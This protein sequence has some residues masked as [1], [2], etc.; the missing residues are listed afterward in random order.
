MSRIAIPD[1]M[2]VHPKS[3]PYYDYTLVEQAFDGRFMSYCSSAG[4]VLYFILYAGDIAVIVWVW[5]HYWEELWMIALSDVSFLCL[6]LHIIGHYL[7]TRPVRGAIRMVQVRDASNMPLWRLP[8]LSEF[9]LLTQSWSIVRWMIFSYVTCI[10]GPALAALV[11]LLFYLVDAVLTKNLVFVVVFCAWQL[12]SS[13][14][15]RAA[16]NV[17]YQNA[18]VGSFRSVFADSRAVKKYAAARCATAV[19]Q[20]LSEIRPARKNHRNG[21]DVAWESS[22][23]D[24]GA[25]L[26][27]ELRQF[28]LN[29]TSFSNPRKIVV[30]QS[31]GADGSENKRRTKR[32]KQKQKQ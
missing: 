8:W 25:D 17:F 18:V 19:N 14:A 23:S 2:P 3:E 24:N 29:R 30:D 28:E 10:V 22:G 12:T 5:T 4:A 6:A 1:D 27:D 9:R 15:L 11:V 7:L 13:C 20:L 26:L 16:V 32:K 31:G 21:T